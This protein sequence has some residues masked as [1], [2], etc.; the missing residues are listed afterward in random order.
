MNYKMTLGVV[1]ILL[2]LTLFAAPLSFAETAMYAKG[3][4]GDPTG[5][6]VGGAVGM[7]PLSPTQ[8]EQ[9]GQG[10]ETGNTGPATTSEG[11]VAGATIPIVTTI[12]VTPDSNESEKIEYM[13]EAL[14]LSPESKFSPTVATRMVRIRHD[15]PISFT[16]IVSVAVSAEPHKREPLSRE[17]SLMKPTFVRRF[18]IKMAKPEH[19]AMMKTQAESYI[20][21]VETRKTAWTIPAP[22]SITRL[23]TKQLSLERFIEE[24]WG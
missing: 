11:H 17:L 10:D 6:V 8:T 1:G 2:A 18:A 9:S 14:K 4:I 5:A 21:S 15:E 12:N 7:E 22:L 23:F 13:K 20:Q 16:S 24:I 3:S 19:N